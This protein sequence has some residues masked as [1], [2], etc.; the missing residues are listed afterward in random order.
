MSVTLQLERSRNLSESTW[1]NTPSEVSVNS[2]L[3]ANDNQ[4]NLRLS[5]KVSW[6]RHVKLLGERSNLS[7][8]ANPRNACCAMHRITFLAKLRFTIPTTFSS[9]MFGWRE[10][11]SHYETNPVRT[12]YSSHWRLLWHADSTCNLWWFQKTLWGYT[13]V[14]Y[15]TIGFACPLNVINFVVCHR[16]QSSSTIIIKTRKKKSFSC[17]TKAFKCKLQNL[18]LY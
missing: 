13:E 3:S 5:L 12:V 11:A 1:I 7:S 8:S 4:L 16:V 15:G 14:W 9:R 10:T 17:N 2:L 18:Q 6:W